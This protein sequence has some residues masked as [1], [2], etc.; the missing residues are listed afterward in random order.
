MLRVYKMYVA[1][2]DDIEAT[3]REAEDAAR[4]AGRKKLSIKET[5]AAKKKAPSG[6]GDAGGGGGAAGG[7]GGGA[8]GGAGAL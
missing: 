1:E 6:E 8:A 5:L 2:L 4:F 3:R 7:G